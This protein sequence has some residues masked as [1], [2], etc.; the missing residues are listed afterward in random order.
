MTTPIDRP[1]RPTTPLEAAARDSAGA[2][3][4]VFLYSCGYNLFLLTPSIYLL[5][6]YDRVLSSRSLDTL[7]MLTLIV[8]VAVVVGTLLDVVRRAALSR[9]ASWL[10][11]RLR[12]E[13]LKAAFG[14]AARVEGGAA[15]QAYRHLATIRQFLESPASAL[16]FDIPWAPVFLGLLFMVHPLLGGIGTLSALLLLGSGFCGDWLTRRPAA[17][18]G[19]AFSHSLSMLS[20]VLKHAALVR[21]MG[22]QDGAL[23]ILDAE[24]D[25]A[26]KANDTAA[27]RTLVVQAFSKSARALTQIVIMGTACWL[28]LKDGSSPGIIFVASLLIG[29]GLAPIEG[30]VGVWKG[31]SHARNACEDLN[32]M[33]AAADAGRARPAIVTVGSAGRLT[34]DNVSLFSPETRQRV[35]SGVSFGLHRGDCLAILGPSGAG[36]SALGRVVAGLARPDE[37]RALLDGC[38]IADLRSG[39]AEPSI[40]YLPQD[41][42][43]FGG[44]IRDV[45]GRFDN[46]NARGVVEA[47]SMVGLHETIMRLPRGY[48]TDVGDGGRALLRAQRQQLGLA[49]AIYG[50]PRLVVLDD[51][52]SSL[53]HRGECLLF[54][55]VRTLRARGVTVVV[56]THRLGILSATNRIAILENG[57]LTAFGESEHIYETRL[58]PPV[59]QAGIA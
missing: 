8:A 28:V 19:H 42:E 7:L 51:P 25:V 56:I 30:A 17:E 57:A 52:N 9:I 26:R 31:L 33:F 37:G 24:A 35:V 23:R 12:P 45:I 10:D 32:R 48:E 6:I 4:C 59:P 16:L 58:R 27:R 53:D 38:G 2:F 20:S 3:A 29:R 55:L 54:Q 14:H 41:I 11:V 15:A 40:G 36:K 39:K 5:Q 1:M 34:I 43:L 47:A 13:V 18:A 22:M 46:R 44:A 50:T 49:R 21:A